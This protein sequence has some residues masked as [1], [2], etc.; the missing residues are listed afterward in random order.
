MTHNILPTTTVDTSSQAAFVKSLDEIRMHVAEEDRERFEAAVEELMYAPFINHDRK[1]NLDRFINEEAWGR[2]ITQVLK[3]RFDANPEFYLDAVTSYLDGKTASEIMIDADKRVLSRLESQLTALKGC[4]LEN[5]AE[6]NETF[7][8]SIEGEIQID[9]AKTMIGQI[10]IGQARYSYPED[11]GFA[12]LSYQITNNTPIPIRKVYIDAILET[13][14]RST[15]WVEDLITLKVPGGIEPGEQLSFK[16]EM[17]H[18]IWKHGPFRNRDDLVLT[19]RALDFEGPEGEC[20]VAQ[21]G[22]SDVVQTISDLERRIAGG[23]K[24]I[25]GLTEKIS[26]IRHH[27]SS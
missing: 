3:A 10:S 6:L 19:L 15:P 20:I 9:L 14:G 22:D 23:R 21:D 4:I 5:E 18:D 13:P 25:E 12:C 1:I 7:A 8:K 24:R 11:G 27:I 2:L 16:Q 17:W 26:E